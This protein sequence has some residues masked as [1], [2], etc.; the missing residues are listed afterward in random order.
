MAPPDVGEPPD[1][2]VVPHAAPA[3]GSTRGTTRPD[4]PTDGAIT[5]YRKR[6]AA[7]G[8]EW[9][10]YGPPI[11]GIAIT[12][13]LIG[14]VFDMAMFDVGRYRVVDGVALA[15]LA[16][17]LDFMHRSIAIGFDAMFRWSVPAFIM[18]SGAILLVPKP[19]S[20]L[21]QY[22][23][24]RYGR[25]MPPVIF[26]SA[27]FMLYGVY[28]LKW[29]TWEQS[30]HNLAIGKPWSHMF[31]IFRFV[32]LYTIAPAVRW[33]IWKL[34]RGAIWG[35]TVA[36]FVWA[37]WDSWTLNQIGQER[38]FIIGTL[39]FLPFFMAGY[40]LRTAYLSPLGVVIAM[41]IWATATVLLVATTLPQI[42]GFND[43]IIQA[44]HA[45]PMVPPS[46]QFAMWDHL[47][48]LRI[49]IGLSMWCVLIT[50][51]RDKKIQSRWPLPFFCNKVAPAAFG[52][53]LIHPLFRDTLH[54]LGFTAAYGDL[55]IGVPVTILL[56]VVLTNI[57]TIQWMKVPYLRKV[58]A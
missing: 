36:L 37:A 43:A 8:H 29:Y 49:I 20:S 54:K 31:F 2:K 13:I 21:V 35:I 19:G 6:A 16:E 57:V 26:W 34:P 15:T 38:G 25:V 55:W 9:L 41:F 14:H 53:Y 7:S 23:K 4:R 42:A 17:P 32:G 45:C 3:D 40:L 33:L 11:R 52:I 22:Y 28:V 18:I 44:A 27:F 24:R 30:W 48:P 50:V 58:I 46:P 51:F 39:Y 10:D 56:V 47:S 1:E 12:A 5:D